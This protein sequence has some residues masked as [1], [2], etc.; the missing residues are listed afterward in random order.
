VKNRKNRS[1]VVIVIVV[2]VAAAGLG[3]TL[4]RGQLFGKQSV[5]TGADP[6]AP[7]MVKVT[8]GSLA[9]SVTA[10]GQLQPSTVTTI[11]PDSNMPTRKLVKLFVAEGQRVQAGQALAEV[12]P[13][14]LDFDLQSATANLEAQKVKLANLKARPAGLDA[15]AAQASLA[16]AQSAL[17]SAQES[18]DSQK[19]LFDQGLAS[20]KDYTDAERALQVAK[21]SYASAHLSFESAKAQNADAD[22]QAQQAA[23]ASAQSELAKARLIYD[24]ITIRSPVKGVVADLNAVIG[25]L[26]SPS[27]A[28]M[29]VVEADPM[30]LVA[31][32]N[33]SDIGQVA[34]GQAVSVTPSGFP[35]LILRG[36]VISIDLHATVQSNVSVFPVTVA[37]PNRD[38]KLLWGMNA[39]A[40]ISVF[41]LPNALLLPSTAI[42]AANGA[43]TVTILDN[44][45]Q[46]AW[47]VQV[48]PSDG[49]KTQIVAGLDEG[50]EVVLS[51]RASSNG[52]SSAQRQGGSPGGM[53]AVFGIM[54]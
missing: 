34:L 40:E 52:A 6:A 43:S 35:D 31:A 4:F 16:S 18:Y 20:K 45:Q 41:S 28:L 27:T 46:V 3:V 10:S 54:R 37:V 17:D 9:V 26:I 33:E 21:A 36:T 47:D 14:G 19:G 39:D 42:R 53:G 2:I 48:G 30:W 22:V 32:V 15:A 11:R 5:K 29:T 13:S 7:T 23:V 44:G 24:S 25:D 49:T 51:R 1:R 38:G 12:D 8:R 50:D